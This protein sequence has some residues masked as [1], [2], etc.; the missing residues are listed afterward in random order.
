METIYK[1]SYWSVNVNFERSIEN[2]GAY[3]HNNATKRA[4]VLDTTQ[5]GENSY[6]VYMNAEDTDSL[7]VGVYDLELWSGDSLL[8]VKS[9]FAK[10][11]TTAKSN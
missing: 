2:F 10:V 3:L 1:G 11:V 8:E 4:D 9:N 7:G 5:I 6:I